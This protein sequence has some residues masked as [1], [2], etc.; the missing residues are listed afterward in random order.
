LVPD[1]AAVTV[2]IGLG[3]AE[4]DRPIQVDECLIE[5]PSALPQ[6]GP[7]T[8]DGRIIRINADRL[9]VVGQ[10]TLEDA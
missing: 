5:R 8:E 2:E 9:V 4:S 3:E 1:Q 7:I 6:N 10:S